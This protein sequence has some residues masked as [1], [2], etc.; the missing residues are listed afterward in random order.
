MNRPHEGVV[1]RENHD[2]FVACFHHNIT[3]RDATKTLSSS[4]SVNLSVLF[5]INELAVRSMKRWKIVGKMLKR[6][7][8][9]KSLGMIVSIQGF[10]VYCHGG[11]KKTGKYLYLKSLNRTIWT[12]FFLKNDSKGFI[13][14]EN[15]DL[16]AIHLIVDN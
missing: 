1:C 10:S 16:I 3:I 4:L 9:S 12:F 7:S 8:V 2:A 11:A 6:K 5:L 15:N 13:N 14:Y